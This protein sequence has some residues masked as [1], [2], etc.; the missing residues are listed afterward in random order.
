MH[1]PVTRSAVEIGRL[2]AHPR[3]DASLSQTVNHATSAAPIPYGRGS[4]FLNPLRGYLTLAERLHDTGA[5]FATGWNFGPSEDDAKPVRWLAD[6]LVR[7]WGP[8]A[9]W[10][11]DVKAHVPEAHFLKLDTSKARTNLNWRPC[12]PLQV[13]LEW[14]VEWFRGYQDEADLRELL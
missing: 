2:S 3:P 4:S 7:L 5:D 13:S 1:V 8:G 14:I 11:C 10:A 6:E 9:G 12:L